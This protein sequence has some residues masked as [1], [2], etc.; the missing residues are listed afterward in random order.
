LLAAT[1][2]L[3]RW[4][5]VTR[6]RAARQPDSS[7][8]AVS[9][10]TTPARVG[11]TG[12][13][14]DLLAHLVAVPDPRKPRGIRHGLSC[15]LAVA[16]AAVLSGARS[17]TAIGEWAAD[18]SQQVLAALGVRPHPRTGRGGAQSQ[19]GALVLQG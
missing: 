1:G 8:G 4:S 13:S 18:A 15:L 5:C 17:F 14:D 2:G 9:G 3:S 12:C 16:A 10:T 11:E 19:V 6:R 7:K